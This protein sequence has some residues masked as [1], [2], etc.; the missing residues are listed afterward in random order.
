MPVVRRSA[1]SQ[2]NNELVSDS[3]DENG[4][5]KPV[6]W[7]LREMRSYQSE[8]QNRLTRIE[9]HQVYIISAVSEA[10]E[11]L[12][13][14]GKD[15]LREV[16]GLLKQVVGYIE[17][18]GLVEREAQSASRQRVQPTFVDVS[19][20]PTP[21]GP[22]LSKFRETKDFFSSPIRH[23]PPHCYDKVHKSPFSR[24]VMKRPE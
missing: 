8:V 19:S 1:T 12:E 18:P 5:S 6:P 13:T 17:K 7:S 10:L 14:A 20:T 9:R 16:K 24:K 4:N 3:C 23:V 11:K 21:R 22:P 2:D 15:D